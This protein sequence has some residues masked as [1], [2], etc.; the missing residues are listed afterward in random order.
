[1]Q[2]TTQF[3]VP[4]WPFFLGDALMLGVAYFIYWQGKVPLDRWELVA[5][6]TCVG[7]AAVLG[8]LPFVLEYRAM[9]RWIDS[10]AVGAAAE[11]IQDLEI[12]AGQISGAANLWEN[13]HLQ[14]EKV[15]GAAREIS[16]RMNAELHDFKE[17][18]QKAGDSERSTLRLE[19]DKLRR[20]EGEWLQLLV[21]ILDHVFALFAA[22][23]RSGQPQLIAQIS[24]FQNACRETVRRVGLIPFVAANSEP[25]DA[26]RHKWA[27]GEAP[28]DGA[29]VGETL[30]TGYTFQG[31]LIRPALVRVQQIEPSQPAPSVD[32]SEPI[33]QSDLPVQSAQ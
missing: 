31:K 5:A 18:L 23:E 17:F 27:D 22:A 13:A 9:T 26:Q 6:G 20:A 29:V 8:V 1:M 7:L 19:V 12:I 10:S 28:A 30:A 16:D 21:R 4:K 25:F 24:Q 11:K 2:D 33:A 14:S 32:G 3:K 15:T